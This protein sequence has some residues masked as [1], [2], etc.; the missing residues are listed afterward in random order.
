MKP[1]S[2]DEASLRAILPGPAERRAI[3]VTARVSQ[4]RIADDLGVTRQAVSLWEIKR[5][6]DYEH[7]EGYVALLAQ[8]AEI[9]KAAQ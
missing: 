7:L 9:N 1:S 2:V 6:P 4:S 5:E 8:L 3:R